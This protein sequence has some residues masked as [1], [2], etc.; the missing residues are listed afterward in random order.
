M[1]INPK[2]TSTRFNLTTIVIIIN[3]TAVIQ[4]NILIIP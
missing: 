3:T 1:A 2:N 4:Y